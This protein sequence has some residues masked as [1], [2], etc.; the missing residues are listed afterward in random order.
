MQTNRMLKMLQEEA[1]AAKQKPVMPSGDAIRDSETIHFEGLP[2]ATVAVKRKDL[3]LNEISTGQ[4]F[5]PEDQSGEVYMV[6]PERGPDPNTINPTAWRIEIAFDGL[7]VAPLR[8]EIVGP[9]VIGRGQDADL[10][11]ASYDALFHGISRRHAMLRPSGRALYFL[12]LSSSN[13]T[14]INGV[15]VRSDMAY[16]VQ[17]ADVIRL[18][19]L[20]LVVRQLQKQ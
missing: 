19:T 3:G 2:Q 17:V 4:Y 10:C 20:T 7:G 18:G 8:L 9:V 14:R 13:G 5:F 6:L 15:D 1:Q 16:T 11:L 12:D